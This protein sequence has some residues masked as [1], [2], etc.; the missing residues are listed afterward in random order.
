LLLLKAAT[1][2][3]ESAIE[4]WRAWYRIAGF[5]GAGMSEFSLLPMVAANVGR[6]GLESEEVPRLLGIYKFN[7]SRNQLQFQRAKKA[8]ATLSSG[9][10]DS[11][12]LK[13]TALTALGYYDRG[14]RVM[15]DIDVM[16][17]TADAARAARLLEEA[18][19]KRSEPGVQTSKLTSIIHAIA[20]T[21]DHGA[22][23]DL[24]WHMIHRDCASDADGLYWASATP[25][26]FVGERTLTPAPSDL[27]L[28]ACVHGMAWMPSPSFIWICDALALIR[29]GNIDWRRL[30]AI[31]AEKNFALPL[32]RA[33]SYL[34]LAFDADIP[35]EATHE[36]SRADAAALDRWQFAIEGGSGLALV[37]LARDLGRYL[38][39]TRA[40]SLRERV[41]T[42]PAYLQTIWK[43]DSGWQ[44]PIW[45]AQQA[46]RRA[47]RLSRGVKGNPPEG[48]DA[49][50]TRAAG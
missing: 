22:N 9:G 40:W 10:I 6:L 30:A 45:M 5:E 29:R 49:H 14:S 35:E 8:L 48:P 20:L 28:H 2:E 17:R 37:T 26:E 13:G 18:G 27:L 31:A 16:V 7:W 25:V 43:V 21:G 11:M 50:I 24:H 12:L 39:I 46:V 44:L 3:G 15:A 23:L 42:M 41:R 38:S 33:L 34:R 1:A 4:A 32:H 47:T 19:W 36:L